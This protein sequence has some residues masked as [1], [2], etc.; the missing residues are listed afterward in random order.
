M[1][2]KSTI[3]GIILLL[4]LLLFYYKGQYV[5]DTFFGGTDVQSWEILNRLGISVH[6]RLYLLKS[7]I[8]S[9][10]HNSLDDIYRV[11]EKS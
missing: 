11:K 1:G 10:C 9:I 8:L 5:T 6:T 2:N 7:N 4:L 3:V